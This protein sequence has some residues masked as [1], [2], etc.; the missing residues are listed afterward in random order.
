MSIGEDGWSK[1]LCG[2]THLS[3]TG[4]AGQFII[5]SEFSNGAGIRRID[6]FVGKKAYLQNHLNHQTVKNL[7][8][9][10]SCLPQELETKASGVLSGLKS[11][12]KE[13]SGFKEEKME[14]KIKDLAASGKSI[15]VEDMG[16]DVSID[17]LRK[18]ATS[19]MSKM[20]NKAACCF[21]YGISL[22][23]PIVVAAS[24]K[25]AIAEGIKAND[26]V[27]A[28]CSAIKGGGGGSAA[29]AQGGG[30]EDQNVK[31]G[32]KAVN[33]MLEAFKAQ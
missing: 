8:S 7:S 33:A 24:N 29:F 21:L 23:A 2:G 3:S 15:F 1:E 28:F 12:Q 20:Q 30:K 32:V 16:R 27:K 9:I 6:A 10:M 11:A 13:L 5:V 25:L 14:A 31:E 18:A 19:L 26:L 22:S 17:L 4:K